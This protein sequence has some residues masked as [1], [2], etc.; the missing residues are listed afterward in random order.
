MI[1]TTGMSRLLTILFLAVAPAFPQA[2]P[3]ILLPEP[4]AGKID[5]LTS[6]EKALITLRSTF[7][8][9]G[10]I[11]RGI[12]AGYDHL[13]DYPE[14]WPQGMEGWSMRYGSRMGR[15]AIRNSLQLGVDVAMKTDPRYDRC[16][17]SGFGARTA[18]A[19]RRVLVARKDHG[20]ETIGLSR[21]VGAYVSPAITDQ[22]YP[23]R[24]N[25]T[26][27]KLQSGTWFLGWRGATNMLREFWPDIKSRMPFGK[28]R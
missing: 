14:E 19:W 17:C 13:R 3:D 11:N 23:D 4:T 21:L 2:L 18:H 12:I 25:T 16:A 1:L 28:K 9:R 8:P 24:L 15:L 26:S 5:P 20:G 10:L 22:W 7:G 6:K 27:H